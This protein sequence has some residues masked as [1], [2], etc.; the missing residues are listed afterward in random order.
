M[1]P[2]NIGVDIFLVLVLFLMFILLFSFVFWSVLWSVLVLICLR[3]GPCH[4]PNTFLV[5]ILSLGTFCDMILPFSSL[6]P[7]FLSQICTVHCT[8][9]SVQWSV[10]IFFIGQNRLTNQRSGIIL[11]VQIQIVVARESKFSFSK[12]FRGPK[13]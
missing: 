6:Y 13:Y 8:L 3:S 10:D 5:L 9:Y 12:N 7:S 1:F 2:L 4:S 11:E